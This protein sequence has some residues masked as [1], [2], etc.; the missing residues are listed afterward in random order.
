MHYNS[1]SLR[2]CPWCDH[3]LPPTLRADALY[4][5]VRCR[6]AAHRAARAKR[7]AGVDPQAGPDPALESPG[8]R[9]QEAEGALLRLAGK[10]IGVMSASLAQNDATV[11]EWIVE[12]TVVRPPKPGDPEEKSARMSDEEARAELERQI[13]IV[14]AE[15]EE[16]SAGQVGPG[17]G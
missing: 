6:Q 13:A 16:E 10:A 3:L 5:S 2:F 11:A 14:E 7:S 15:L 1:R 8:S 12:R 17:T 9:R 4:C